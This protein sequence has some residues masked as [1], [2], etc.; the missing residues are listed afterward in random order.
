MDSTNTIV[1]FTKFNARIEKNVSDE[2][3]SHLKGYPNV[4]INPDFKRVKMEKPHYWKQGRSK[5][6]YRMTQAE[7]DERDQSILEFE[8]K[9][10]PIANLRKSDLFWGKKP[11]QS[12]LPRPRY[13]VILSKAFN[14]SFWVGLGIAIAYTWIHSH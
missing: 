13:H 8:K 9:N 7:K 11:H 3:V 14:R 5:R 1:I 2:E 12:I 10:G 4:S 6:I